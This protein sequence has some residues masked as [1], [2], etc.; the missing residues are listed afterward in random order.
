MYHEGKYFIQEPWA[1][2]KF[3]KDPDVIIEKHIWL[4]LRFMQRKRVEVKLND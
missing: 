1:D 2:R 3:T 4:V